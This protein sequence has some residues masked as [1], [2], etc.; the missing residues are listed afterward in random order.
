MVIVRIQGGLAN[1]MFQYAFYYWLTQKH[2]EKSLDIDTYIDNS[3]YYHR[4]PSQECDPVHNGYELEKVFGIKDKS[5]DLKDVYRLSEYR[6]DIVRKAFV[7][8]K[9]K[10]AGRKKTQIGDNEDYL[11]HVDLATADEMYFSGTWAAKF[12]YANDYSSKIRDIFSFPEIV[13]DNNMKIRLKIEETNS[14]SI[15]VRRGDYLNI[16]NGI[17]LKKD[18]Y[19]NAIEIIRRRV[20]HPVFFVFSDDIEWCKKN[21]NYGDTFFIDWNKGDESYRDMQL[22]SLCKHNIIANST[23][24]AWASWLNR[25]EDRIVISPES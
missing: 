4:V 5:A 14:V 20:N 3:M 9:V 16:R 12:K 6:Y 11:E 21:I 23:F 8:A 10:L 24:S 15:H 1:Q 7:K 17:N 25:N 18:Y 13:D 2:I 22:M 19:D